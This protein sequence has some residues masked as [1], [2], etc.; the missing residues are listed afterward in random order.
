M[1]FFLL[2]LIASFTFL[3]ANAVFAKQP[4][5]ELSVLVY[6][7]S[8]FPPASLDP[9][10]PL[11]NFTVNIYQPNGALIASKKTDV[12]GE[13]VFDF[14]Y[15]KYFIAAPT[16]DHLAYV[17]TTIGFVFTPKK[18]VAYLYLPWLYTRNPLPPNVHPLRFESIDLD[19]STSEHE[20]MLKCFPGQTLS[21]KVSWWE[22]ETTHFPVW[23]VSLFGDWQPT[24]ALSNLASGRSSPST[25]ELY[26][27]I[28]TFNAPLEPGIYTVR[29]VGV[30]DYSWPCSYFT[31]F[32]YS[33]HL[34]RDTRIGILGQEPGEYE[35]IGMATI[36]V[37]DFE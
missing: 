3:P 12:N 19:T 8:G 18:K 24:I 23:Y 5:H 17:P 11:E 9:I 14:H 33:A 27:R 20:T 7:E 31:R 16:P 34:G 37:V 29:V 6:P 4:K 28:A 30:L 36:K 26:K 15:G 10:V 2:V 35:N 1:A 25:H 21:I 13:A 22:L 32:H